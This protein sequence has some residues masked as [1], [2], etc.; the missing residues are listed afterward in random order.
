M[1]LKSTIPRDTLFD[2]D[3]VMANAILLDTQCASLHFS[4]TCSHL[5]DTPDRLPGKLSR[6][7]SDE[8]YQGQLK[9][10]AVH[11]LTCSVR[12]VDVPDGEEQAIESGIEV[13]A[14][15][16]TLYPCLS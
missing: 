13:S 3:H 9:S 6:F 15:A 4:P 10:T 2:L 7:M 12:F 11:P 16:Q 5:R 14:S 1:S 8:L